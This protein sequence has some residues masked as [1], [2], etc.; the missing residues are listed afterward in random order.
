MHSVHL[1]AGTHSTNP[2]ERQSVLERALPI[3]I[4]KNCWM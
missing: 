2:T 4:G 3:K 1:Y